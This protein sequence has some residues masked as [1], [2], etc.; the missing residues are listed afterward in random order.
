VPKRSI[1]RLEHFP[2]PLAEAVKIVEGWLASAIGLDGLKVF[3]PLIS[4]LKNQDLIGLQQEYRDWA[5][6]RRLRHRVFY[7]TKP[8]KGLLTVVSERDADAG[9]KGKPIPCEGKDHFECCAPASRSDAIFTIVARF[10]DECRK[11]IASAKFR[12]GGNVLPANHETLHGREPV[13]AAIWDAWRGETCNVFAIYGA[14]GDGKTSV[15]EEFIRQQIKTGWRGVER[16]FV[17]SFSGQ[18]GTDR[19][20]GGITEFW[21]E[22]AREFECDATDTNP[23]GIA[24]EV[25]RRVQDLHERGGRALIVLDGLEVHQERPDTNG[26]AQ[27]RD[28]ALRRLITLLTRNNC[29][30]LVLTSQRDVHEL[31][32]SIPRIVER[33]LTPLD[34]QASFRLIAEQGIADPAIAQQIYERSEGRPLSLI[35][36]PN[37]FTVPGAFQTPEA[38]GTVAAAAAEAQVERTVEHVLTELAAQAKEYQ[39]NK[40]AGKRSNGTGF[41]EHAI[42]L[43]LSL[44]DKPASREEL[45]VVLKTR[46]LRGFPKDLLRDSGFGNLLS[47][48]IKRLVGQ[49][50]LSEKS[51]AGLARNATAKSLYL[52]S[53]V[54][55]NLLLRLQQSGEEYRHAHH[56]LWEYHLGLHSKLPLQLQDDRPGALELFRAATHAFESGHH[57]KAFHDIYLGRLQGPKR[58][59][60]GAINVISDELQFLSKYF[61]ASWHQLRA[62]L[63]LPPETEIELYAYSHY[64][65]RSTGRIQ[66]ALR[67]IEQCERLPSASASINYCEYLIDWTETLLI[68]GRIEEASRKAHEARNCLQ[69]EQGTDLQRVRALLYHAHCLI[70]L[71]RKSDWS[72]IHRA[73][74]AAQELQSSD[75]QFPFLM[76]V[77]G[78]LY[79]QYLV[80]AGRR[81]EA[82]RYALKC[83][84]EAIDRG[85]S[86]LSLGLAEAL[87]A[88]SWH[89]LVG[90]LRRPTNP[91]EISNLN[92]GLVEAFKYANAAVERLERCAQQHFIVEALLVR[93]G[94]A[95]ALGNDTVAPQD[96]Q[97]SQETIE[98]SELNFYWVDWA[99]ECA[100]YLVAN[101]RASEAAPYEALAHRYI[102]ENGHHRRTA[103]LEALRAAQATPQVFASLSMDMP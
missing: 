100:R 20:E 77:Q 9:V 21:S 94:L 19:T 57:L 28:R 30:M 39:A 103:G 69:F 56:A 65:L 26:R 93:S 63:D 37:W 46:P 41:I 23:D 82:Y 6:E 73:M 45:E 42:L 72:E 95:R 13:L 86:S 62:D 89:S 7:E 59:L 40:A 101:D 98:R 84:K 90:A 49:R 35:L 43:S 66:Q 54:R 1:A 81:E 17:W 22:I 70:Q 74:H 75:K 25:A 71:G 102:K 99:L 16:A 68:T 88:R 8:T 33:R 87:V 67:T 34:R 44:F 50:L 76:G 27:V 32:G 24:A 31:P 5:N 60:R 15:A 91:K 10:I 51:I 47:N 29:G 12:F 79:G 3:S 48:A 97:L 92:A 55:R 78:Y 61:D 36:S 18:G 52:H 96:L 80:A 53:D 4:D 58:R 38:S 14:A 64:V 2:N 11:G 83:R 85:L